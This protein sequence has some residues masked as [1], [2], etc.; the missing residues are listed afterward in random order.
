[1][2]CKNWFKADEGIWEVRNGPFHFVYS[3][4]MC[5][6]ALDRGMTIA[7]RYGLD[8]PLTQ[9]KKVADNIKREVLEKGYSDNINSFTQYYGS[10]ELDASLILLPLMKFLP[11]DDWRIQSTIGKIK[12]NLI[13]DGFLRRYTSQDGLKGEEG[14][15]LI[16]NFWL[17]ECLVL[18]GKVDEAKKGHSFSSIFPA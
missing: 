8:A 11:V 16:C 12:E 14:S 13:K 9:W 6:V 5:W 10:D 3:K 18:L 4:V 15:F 2:A 17:I 1:L 7:R